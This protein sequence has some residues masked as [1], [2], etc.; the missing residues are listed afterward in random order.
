MNDG[1][2][3]STGSTVQKYEVEVSPQC[4]GEC[5]FR[6]SG[7]STLLTPALPLCSPSFVRSFKNS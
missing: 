2:K 6:Q 3:Y 5:S 4:E 7:C 1:I